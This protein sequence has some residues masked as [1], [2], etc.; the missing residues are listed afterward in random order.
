[1]IVVYHRIFL[2]VDVD[3]VIAER[4]HFRKFDLHISNL[5]A[6][7]FQAGLMSKPACF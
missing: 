4:L 3:I 7:M 1:M 5:P 2:G 6:C